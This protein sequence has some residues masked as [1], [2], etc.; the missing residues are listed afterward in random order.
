M[1][2]RNNPIVRRLTQG[3][4][5]VAVHCCRFVDV[6]EDAF[7]LGGRFAGDQAGFAAAVVAQAAGDFLA[8]RTDAGD[9]GAAL[10]FALD[11]DYTDRQQAFAAF[12]RVDCAGVQNQAA[13]Q[14]QVVGQPLFASGERRGLRDEQGTDGFASGQAADRIDFAAA[15]DGGV[16]AASGGAFCGDHLGD[17]A[18]G[19]DSGAGAAGHRFERGVAG[20]GFGDQGG[21]R[22]LARVGG[23]EAD[24]VGQNDQRVGFDQVGNQGAQR[25]VVAELDFVGDHRV[26]FVDDRHDAEFEQGGQRRAGVQVALAVGQV[27]VG[28]QDLGGVQAVLVE[29]GLVGFDQSGLPDGGGGLLFMNGFRAAAPAQALDAAGDGPGGNQYDFLALLAEGGDLPGPVADRSEVQAATVVGDE[30]R[31]D[32]DDE[33]FGVGKAGLGHHSSVID[34]LSSVS[35]SG[36]SGRSICSS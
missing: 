27:V 36:I 31:A 20:G 13:G 5:V 9:G 32:F 16:S 6:A 11:R 14:L 33:A 25:V 8:V 35:S 4:Q 3:D 10:E 15:G 29:G 18:A 28:E 22:V 30:R 12:Q 17:H 24:L 7:D 34:S 23:V 19:A 26:V 21:V 1:P 2:R